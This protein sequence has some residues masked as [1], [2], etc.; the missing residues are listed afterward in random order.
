MSPSGRRRTDA[1]AERAGSTLMEA[2]RRWLARMHHDSSRRGG[3]LLDMNGDVVWCSSSAAAL[4]GSA[5]SALYRR[6]PWKTF[7]RTV[8]DAGGFHGSR[9]GQAIA[10][11][12]VRR[13]DGESFVRADGAIVSAQYLV[14]PLHDGAEQVGTLLSFGRV[15]D[16]VEEPQ[17]WA[18]AEIRQLLERLP[19]A[20]YYWE[21]GHGG[22]CL[23]L[24]PRIAQLTGWHAREFVDDHAHWLASIH[25][26]DRDAAL[27]REALAT[28][29]GELTAEYRMIG[30][31][32]RVTWIRDHAVT[33]YDVEGTPLYFQGFMED[34]TERKRAEAELEYQTTHDAAT[35]LPN[36]QAFIVALEE[37]LHRSPGVAVLH[38]DLDRFKLLNESFGHV[39]GDAV[40]SDVAKRLPSALRAGDVLARFGGDEFTVLLREA[41]AEAAEAVAAR[42]LQ[43]L[44][45]PFSHA[46]GESY[47]TASIGISLA[48]PGVSATDL[49]RDAD[50]ALHRAKD[51]G[52]SR[53]AMFD[54]SLRARARERLETEDDLHRALERE[55][56]AVVFQPI[57]HLATGTVVAVETLLRWHHPLRG[58]L[59]PSAFIGV[60]EDTGLIVEIDRWVLREAC[61]HGRDLG[62]ALAGHAPLPRVNVN[63]SARHPLGSDLAGAVREALDAAELPPSRLCLELTESALL[64]D[65]KH[66]A[67]ILAGV[68]ALG[69]AVT[70]DD[71]GVGWSSLSHL[72]ELPVD[73]LKIDRSFVAGLPTSAIDRALVTAIVTLARSMGIPAVAEGVEDAAQRDLLRELQCEF[74]QGYLFARPCRA[75]EVLELVL[76]AATTAA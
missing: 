55:E 39:A 24:S 74:G 17:P 20:V 49:I 43:T 31:D 57:V 38:L 35:S 72:R 75:D 48:T 63:V 19:V 50:A 30:P 73:G 59:A 46:H 52:K 71:F 36:R 27:A 70:L 7:Y 68:R 33:V 16:G 41:D 65:T 67:D 26:D 21:V 58:A 54:R 12:T 40:L 14:A 9:L 66:A 69:V 1:P 51:L 42:L 76:D 18:D 28:V 4:I 25:P 15:E 23:Y 3:I 2:L 53:F 13:L 22:R 5:P 6:P 64:A 8:A 32:G 29:T 60:A 37:G 34:V 61:R 45:A 56:L 62:L 11:G 47:L 44:A 10:A